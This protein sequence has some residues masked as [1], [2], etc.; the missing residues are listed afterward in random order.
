MAPSVYYYYY[1]DVY[2][3]RCLVSNVAKDCFSTAQFYFHGGCG[4]V[5]NISANGNKLYDFMKISPHLKSKQQRKNI[6][7]TGL[8]SVNLYPVFVYVQ[9]N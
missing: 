6:E 2:L 9:F 8:L 3:S 4:D 1:F 7:F 5:L